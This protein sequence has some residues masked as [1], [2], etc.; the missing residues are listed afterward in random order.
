M[1]TWDIWY[2]KAAANG[3]LLARCRIDP[4][5]HVIVHAA[6]DVLTVE[7]S[8][9]AGTR[10]AYGKDLPRTH[11]SPM[12]L[13]T[14]HGADVTREDIWPSEGHIGDTVL[15]PGGEAGVLK[16]WWNAGDRNEWRWQV[17]FYNSRR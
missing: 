7:V 15:L 4:A 8:G 14:I 11:D 3:L 6:P 1:D 10:R 9:D 12:C 13:L 2:P 17:E 5:N 16:S